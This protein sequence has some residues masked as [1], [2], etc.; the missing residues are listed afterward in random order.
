MRLNCKEDAVFRVVAR[1]FQ[2]FKY[3]FVTCIKG[4]LWFDFVL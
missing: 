4:P 1:A 3:T 2:C